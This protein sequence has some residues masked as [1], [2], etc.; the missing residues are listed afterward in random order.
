MLNWSIRRLFLI[1]VACISTQSFAHDI[2]Y[3]CKVV[4]QSNVEKPDNKWRQ[5][6][7]RLINKGEPTLEAILHTAIAHEKWRVQLFI[8]DCPANSFD[9]STCV[10]IGDASKYMDSAGIPPSNQ[11]RDFEVYLSFSLLKVRGYEF[12]R[13]IIDTPHKPPDED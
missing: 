6:D 8:Y 5:L 7:I 3:D 12:Y 1:I 11:A 2:E 10:Q 13:C 9:K 4:P